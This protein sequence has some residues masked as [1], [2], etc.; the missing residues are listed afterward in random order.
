MSDGVWS[1]DHGWVVPPPCPVCGDQPK[2]SADGRWWARACCVYEHA[3]PRATVRRSLLKRTINWV[4]NFKT[5]PGSAL[6]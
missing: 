3:L 1:Q 5:K 4:K 2:M 6:K